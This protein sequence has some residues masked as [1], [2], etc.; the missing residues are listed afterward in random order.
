MT[1]TVTCITH[2]TP[3]SHVTPV[4][5]AMPVRSVTPV[6]DDCNAHE[7]TMVHVTLTPRATCVSRDA[8]LHLHL[9]LKF[10]AKV[11]KRWLDRTLVSLK[12]ISFGCRCTCQWCCRGRWCN[13]WLS[14]YGKLKNHFLDAV[15]PS[16][17]DIVLLA[18]FKKADRTK[19]L[20]FC[21]ATFHSKE[22]TNQHSCGPGRARC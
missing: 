5:Y 1:Q 20:W 19:T 15:L 7:T 16:W 8:I 13:K 3:A 17:G 14:A 22:G 9:M 2:V 18:L 6:A 11:G 12:K 4:A 10:S 21:G